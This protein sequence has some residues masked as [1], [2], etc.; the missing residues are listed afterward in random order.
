MDQIP[1]LFIPQTTTSQQKD[2]FNDWA[3]AQG[4][5]FSSDET[6]RANRIAN[7]LRWNRSPDFVHLS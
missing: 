4:L 7:P 1:A 6:V 5:I 2:T 3:Q